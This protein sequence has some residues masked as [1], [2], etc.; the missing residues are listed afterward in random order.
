MGAIQQALV[1]AEGAAAVA[2][3][4]FTF[5]PAVSPGLDAHGFFVGAYGTLSPQTYRGNQIRA[6]FM[7]TVDGSARFQMVGNL[8]KSYWSRMV[9]PGYFDLL[10]V[11]SNYTYDS[12]DN[13][14]TWEYSNGMNIPAS[15]SYTLTIYN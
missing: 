8:P 13:W 3:S 1:V 5:G 2:S 6:L 15:G 4:T 10:S 12:I 7:F 11:N 9:L 14:S